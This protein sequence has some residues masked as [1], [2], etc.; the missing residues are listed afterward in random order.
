MQGFSRTVPVRSGL[1][2]CPEG[3]VQDTEMARF[4]VNGPGWVRAT[5]MLS[6]CVDINT[7]CE[8]HHDRTYLY[9]TPMH[10]VGLLT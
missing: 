6:H 8:L 5:E 4:S 9:V 3:S 1:S 10:H 7:A 2:R